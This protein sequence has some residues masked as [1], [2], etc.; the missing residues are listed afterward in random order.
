MHYHKL[1][2]LLLIL[3]IS[4]IRNRVPNIPHFANCL[5]INATS[6]VRRCLVSLLGAFSFHPFFRF[7]QSGES[8]PS[9]YAIPT[10]DYVNL[11]CHHFRISVR[12]F[13]FRWGTLKVVRKCKNFRT[14]TNQR[15]SFRFKVS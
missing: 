5:N 11:G 6:Y 8:T 10:Y 4:E 13:I 2:T 1:L 9:R 15:K 14:D 3:M 12:Y 7:P